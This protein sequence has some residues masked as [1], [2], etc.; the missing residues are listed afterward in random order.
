MDHAQRR[1]SVI[2]AMSHLAVWAG[3]YAVGCVVLVFGILGEPLRWR[4]LVIALVVTIGTY[5]LDRVGGWSRR[6]DRGDLA[7]VP[8]RVRFLR[9]QMPRV[10]SVAICLLVLGVVL[11]LDE[12]WQ[13]AVLV[14]AAVLGMLV[15]GH[16]PKTVR[17]KDRLFIKNAAVAASLTGFSLVLVATRGASR[18]L[19]AWAIVAGVLFLHVLAGAMLCD[20]DDRQAD[21]RHGTRTFPNTIGERW[22]RWMADGLVVAAGG[23]LL[24]SHS[25]GWVRGDHAVLL[26]TLPVAGVLLLHITRPAAVRELVDVIFPVAVALAMVF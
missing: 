19:W 11:A 24:V 22:T 7:S 15:Y 1:I 13:V 20:V 6:P 14:P 5:M 8:R 16:V 21:A 17:L 18:D 3:C 4:P 23:L 26:A 12:G 9:Q 10:R 25:A 2:E